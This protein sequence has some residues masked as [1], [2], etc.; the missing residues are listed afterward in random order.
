MKAIFILLL[1]L[2]VF[3]T[4]GI[5]TGGEASKQAVQNAG[6]QEKAGLSR[7]SPKDGENIDKLPQETVGT[8]AKE[9]SRPPSAPKGL[10]IIPRSK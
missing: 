3:L 9:L 7:S 5:S 4:E 1:P 2:L 6:Q 8:S 10:K